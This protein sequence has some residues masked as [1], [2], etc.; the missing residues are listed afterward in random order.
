GTAMGYRFYQIIAGGFSM[1]IL[2]L[3]A[4]LIGAVLP[5]G[6]RL[7]SQR[8]ADLG[9][10]VGR[11]LTWNTLGAVVGVL[12]TGFILM[13]R[14]GLR[15]AFNVLALALCVPVLFWAWSLR[16]KI[17]VTTGWLLVA[18]LV[19]SSVAGGEGWHLVMSSGVFR[20]RETRVDPGAM[21][22]RKREVKILFYEDAADATV[23]VEEF[24]PTTDSVNL[25]LRI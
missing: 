13:P 12:L 10:Q 3:P 21:E 1:I 11:L 4:A 15:N 9:N 17:I 8:G 14:A 2:G 19:W 22:L 7:V 20:A 18:G 6:I 5:L 23:S 16:R 24:H 25:S